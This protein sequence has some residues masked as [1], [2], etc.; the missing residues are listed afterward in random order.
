L[1]LANAG[2][3][4]YRTDKIHLLSPTQYFDL[5]STLP[6]DTSTDAIRI[7]QTLRSSLHPIRDSVVIRSF[8]CST[9]FTQSPILLR[10][11]SWEK[12]GLLNDEAGLLEVLTQLP[13]ASE[14]ELAK[15]IKPTLDALLVILDRNPGGHA[16]VEEAAFDALVVVITLAQDRRFSNFKPVSLEPTSVF[17]L[18][19]ETKLTRSHTFRQ[20]LEIYIEQNLALGSV[21][22]NLI[23]A[24]TRLLGDQT[25]KQLRAAIK[26]WCVFLLLVPT[27][28]SSPSESRAR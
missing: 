7:P 8:L 14:F 16:Q 23:S 22:V 10:L 25:S 5:P 27:L 20:V 21:W 3:V 2:L 15:T 26:N 17:N 28:L 19:V 13:F 24:M 9:S 18:F 11:L 4:L 12:S 6:S 1:N